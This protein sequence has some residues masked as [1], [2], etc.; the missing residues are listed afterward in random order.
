MDP[1]TSQDVLGDESLVC[2]GNRKTVS[3]LPS[4]QPIHYTDCNISDPL[5]NNNS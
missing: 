1:T 2:V 4:P 3:L 5:F